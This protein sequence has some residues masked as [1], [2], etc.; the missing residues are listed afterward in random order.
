MSRLSSSSASHWQ[1]VPLNVS[2]DPWVSRLSANPRIVHFAASADGLIRQRFGVRYIVGAILRN[3][4]TLEPHGH[5]L[6]AAARFPAFPQPV[7]ASRRHPRNAR[8]PQNQRRALTMRTPARIARLCPAQR[9]ADILLSRSNR[10]HI[11][12]AG[13]VSSGSA[14]SARATKKSKV[15]IAQPQPRQFPGTSQRI[16][17]DCLKGAGKFASPAA[18]STNTSDL[19]V[20]LVSSS[21]K[22]RP[23]RCHHL[24][25]RFRRRQRTPACEDR[26]GETACVPARSAGR[27]SSR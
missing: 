23:R 24:R 14:C 27:S 17:A 4:S 10:V 1:P 22:H 11:C 16:L 20:R 9:S 12:C 26:H 7:P 2:R 25:R 13:P 18:S 6:G 19:S 5:G 3:A 8:A 15:P 21:Q